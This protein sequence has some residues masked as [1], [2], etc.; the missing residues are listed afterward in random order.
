LIASILKKNG[1]VFPA[2]VMETEFRSVAIAAS[3]FTEDIIAKVQAIFTQDT[4]RHSYGSIHTFLS[5]HMMKKGKVGRIQL[6]GIQ[7][8]PRTS[9]KPR[10]KWFLIQ[11]PVT[12]PKQ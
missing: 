7:D 3:M 6:S 9:R 1:A 4:K 5:V 8:Q 10:G 2:N 12:T 11:A